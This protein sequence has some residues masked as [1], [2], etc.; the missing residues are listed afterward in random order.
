MINIPGLPELDSLFLK[1]LISILIVIIGIIFGKI[2]G[3]LLKKISKSLELNKHIRGSFID[4]IILV[5]KWSTYLIFINLALKYLEIPRFTE[6]FETV[7]ITIPAFVGALIILAIGFALAIY[8]REV[9]E[10]AE[11]TGWDL[12]SLVIFYFVLYVFGV[13]ALKTA[14]IIFDETTTNFIILILTAIISTGTVYTLIKKGKREH[15]K[16][17]KANLH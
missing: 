14:L 17:I 15:I 2:I 11:V 5:I 3:Y 7:L 4:L 10:D 13:Y 12:I 6:F 16:E 1:A 9:I 8:L